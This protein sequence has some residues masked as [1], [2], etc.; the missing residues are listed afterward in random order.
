MRDYKIADI[1]CIRPV[2]DPQ[3]GW[4]ALKKKDE[5]LFPP[6]VAG[7]EP[8]AT[9]PEKYRKSITEG[10][11]KQREEQQNEAAA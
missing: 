2:G 9:V 6:F 10:L 1:S 8:P 11:K 4:V 3:C 5:R 7:S